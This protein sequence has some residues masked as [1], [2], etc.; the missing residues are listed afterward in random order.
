[1]SLREGDEG[2]GGE[3]RLKENYS[4]LFRL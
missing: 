1:M 3:S 4:P 2:L